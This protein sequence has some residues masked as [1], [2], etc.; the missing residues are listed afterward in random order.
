VSYFL[1]VDDPEHE[2][3][4]EIFYIG[5]SQISDVA[6]EKRIVRLFT[7]TKV[8]QSIE[9]F[10]PDAGNQKSKVIPNATLLICS[11]INYVIY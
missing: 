6:V 7:A 4:P 2:I 11:F 3:E 10:F 9:K 5:Y 1:Q 8:H